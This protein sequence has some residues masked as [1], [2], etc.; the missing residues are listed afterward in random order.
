[1]NGPANFEYGQSRSQLAQQ[2]RDTSREGQQAI[3]EAVQSMAAITEGSTKIADIVSLIDSIAFQTNLLA[4]N[5]SVEAARAGEEGR[6][7]AVVAGEVRQLANRS[8]SA[9]QDIKGLIVDSNAR[10]GVSTSVVGV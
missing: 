7:F 1:M 6:G 8:A 10:V 4:L 3:D 5:A 2:A 9:A